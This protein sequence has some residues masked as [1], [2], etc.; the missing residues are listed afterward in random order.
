[1]RRLGLFFLLSLILH[2]IAML[3][4]QL[5]DPDFKL[6]KPQSQPIEINIVQSTPVSKLD[7]FSATPQ[8][9]AIPKPVSDSVLKNNRIRA[10]KTIPNKTTATATAILESEAQSNPKLQDPPDRAHFDVAVS[11]A[12]NTDVSASQSSDSLPTTPANK[13]QTPLQTATNGL[14]TNTKPDNLAPPAAF[15]VKALA[16]AKLNMT[17]IRT[18]ADGKEYRGSASLQWQRQAERY[19]LDI[20]AGIRIV[21]ARI[22][23]YQL[24]SRGRLGALGITPETCE[25][26]RLRRAPTATHFLYDEQQISFSAT[27][28]KIA[29]EAGAQDKASVILQLAAI[30]NAD[31]SQFYPNRQI[32]I[33][34]AEEKEANL[35]TFI[36]LGK[37]DIETGLGYQTAWHVVRPPKP[38]TY[39]SRLD[40]WFAP[41][42]GWYPIQITSTESNGTV[43]VQNVTKI[44]PLPDTL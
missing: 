35:F 37:E 43:T 38:G 33:Q 3:W 31:E 27:D 44:T 8:K 39:N 41:E 34:V 19:Q 11:E 15:S 20:E 36:V 1:M 21:F 16:S 17:V 7:P 14:E 6:L 13:L 42:L 12:S 23:L 26:N 30:G 18:E 5:P 40:I 29:L 4:L 10:A 25:E 32:T 2:S 22:N 28:K 24:H 9:T